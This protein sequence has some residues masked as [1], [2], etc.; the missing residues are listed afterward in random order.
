MT[1]ETFKQYAKHKD[2]TYVAYQMSKES[3][4]LLDHFVEMNLGLTE[5]IDPETYHITIIYSRTP[6][7][8]AEQFAG[9]TTATANA[10]GYEVFPTKTGD[11]CL[12]LRVQSTQAEVFN[13][14]LGSLG[15][16]SDYDAYKPHVTICYTYTGES[17]VADLPLPQFPL[18]FDRIDVSPLD[19]QFVP[20]NK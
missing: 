17:D 7:P 16:T 8:T 2:G 11:K 3:R 6:V 18:Y 4:D 19:P 12:V 1:L 13:K 14:H 10:V 15:A 9:P 20:G 5:R